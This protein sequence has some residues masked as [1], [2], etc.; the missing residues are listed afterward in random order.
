[1]IVLINGES[2]NA[3]IAATDKVLR[4]AKR[5]RVHFGASLNFRSLKYR[6]IAYPRP[7]RRQRSKSQVGY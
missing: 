2:N 3:A 7:K 4:K 5:G 1:L 6:N